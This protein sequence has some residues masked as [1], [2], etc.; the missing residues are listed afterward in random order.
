[1]IAITRDDG[2]QLNRSIE[3]VRAC[4]SPFY[5]YDFVVVE[6]DSKDDTP[7]ILKAFDPRG[8]LW[9][10]VFFLSAGRCFGGSAMSAA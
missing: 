10:L 7:A 5:D 6:S 9:G 4:M 3:I 8:G 1:V 2:P